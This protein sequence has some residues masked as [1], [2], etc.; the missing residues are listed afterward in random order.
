MHILGVKLDNLSRKEIL[1]K[2]GVFASEN[3]FHHISTI[4]PEF[5]IEAQRNEKFRDILNTCDLNIADGIG[6][7]FAFYRLGRKL[8]C[9]MPG[10][11]LMERIL[12]IAEKNKLDVFLAINNQGLSSWE[13]VREKIIENYPDLNVDGDNIDMA[14]SHYEILSSSCQVVLCNFGAPHQET[15]IRAQKNDRMRIAMGVGGSFDF[16]TGKVRRAP[17]LWRLFGL[18]WLWRLIQK[19]DKTRPRRW[20]RIWNAVIIFPIKVLMNNQ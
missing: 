16:M 19:P 14:N 11:D 8:K 6:I 12:R 17:Y 7:K 1:E 20:K 2:V 3:K 9:R 15:F 13:E 10:A 5:I 4:N 18:E